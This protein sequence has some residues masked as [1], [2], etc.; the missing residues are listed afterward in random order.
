MFSLPADLLEAV[1]EVPDELDLEVLDPLERHVL[2]HARS[3]QVPSGPRVTSLRPD[4]MAIRSE[5][6]E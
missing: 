1:E 3:W 6:A 2:R 4:D 5:Y